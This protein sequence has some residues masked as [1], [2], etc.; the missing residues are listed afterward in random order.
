[1]NKKS[2]VAGLIAGTALGMLFAPK[3]GKDIRDK[4]KDEFKDGKTGASVLKNAIL[5]IGKEMGDY[6][7]KN[8]S[9]EQ[10]EKSKKVLKNVKSKAEKNLKNI[11]DD[12]K[13]VTDK[14]SE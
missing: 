4:L 13:T 6:C 14:I 5:E 12:I 10:I 11:V 1:M 2:I 8:L 7:T 9:K 3:K